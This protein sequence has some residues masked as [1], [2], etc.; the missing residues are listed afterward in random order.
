MRKDWPV[1]LRK[2]CTAGSVR[3]RQQKWAMVDLRTRTKLETA[4]GAKESL[5][6]MAPSSILGGRRAARRFRHARPRRACGRV[7]EQFRQFRGA[8]LAAQLRQFILGGRDF[9]FEPCPGV[10]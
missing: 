5:Q 3:G 9:L 4:D 1:K 2:I 10:T 7:V 8:A 6:L